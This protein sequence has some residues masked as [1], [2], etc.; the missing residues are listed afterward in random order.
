MGTMIVLVEQNA[1]PALSMLSS[2]RASGFWWPGGAYAVCTTAL[3]KRCAH[4]PM[5]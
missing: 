4:D 2:T 5:S 1:L 3:A